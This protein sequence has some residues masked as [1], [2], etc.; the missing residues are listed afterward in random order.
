MEIESLLK[1]CGTL[2]VLIV[3]TVQIQSSCPNLQ[4][5]NGRGKLGPVERPR[6]GQSAFHKMRFEMARDEEGMEDIKRTKKGVGMSWIVVG[7]R[8]IIR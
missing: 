4:K 1:S 7:R 5:E 8:V 2:W 6:E 3:S